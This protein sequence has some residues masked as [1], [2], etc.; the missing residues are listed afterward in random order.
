MVNQLD[1]APITQVDRP[2]LMVDSHNRI[3]IRFIFCLLY[4]LVVWH[5]YY[6]F[7]RLKN[8]FYFFYLLIIFSHII[9]G[10]KI[11]DRKVSKLCGSKNQQKKLY[12]DFEYKY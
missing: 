9:G 8:A 1:S 12:F 10:I 3:V 6:I 11:Y 5:V 4:R 2:Y 7:S